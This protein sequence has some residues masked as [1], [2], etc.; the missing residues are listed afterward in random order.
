MLAQ[1][2]APDAA[3]RAAR[4]LEKYP[5]SAAALSL[6]VEAQIAR[7]GSLAG[8][9]QYERWLAQRT[10][11]EPGVL[12]RIAHSLLRE[13]AFQQADAAARHDALEALAREQDPAA[14]AALKGDA[15]DPAQL[16]LRA[17]LGDQAAVKVLLA[18]LQS[19]D[20]NPTILEALGR[21]G[22]PAAVEPLVQRLGDPRPEI[23]GAAADAL[24]E[25]DART[26]LPRLKTLLS[27]QSSFVRTQAAAALLRMDDTTGV[28]LLEN[29]M[30]SE[31]AAGRLIGVEAL[32]SR[33]DPSWQAA[34]RSLTE[35][36]EPE[37]RL[38]G[39]RLIAPYD[40][41]LASRVLDALS[42]DNN[43]VIRELAARAG[44]E[45][46]AGNLTALRHLMRNAD[47]TVRIR[48]AD[49]VLSLTR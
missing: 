48:S 44:P 49:R 38:A 21:S 26:A 34:A 28:P 29:L 41:D 46:A 39:A 31:S 12:R 3:T 15:D 24:G 17:T 9:D 22:S 8:L 37:V 13:A 36:A 23:R 11:E 4:I 30:T 32:A 2:A 40:P 16:R 18:R 45:I 6:A 5:R 33:P 14:A 42:R 35:A 10:I 20:N 19:G 1:G 25:L 47:R 7:G 43:P 27:D